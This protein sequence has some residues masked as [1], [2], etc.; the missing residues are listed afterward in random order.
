[1]L[2]GLGNTTR[3]HPVVKVN[4]N[5]PKRRSGVHP[6]GQEAFRQNKYHVSEPE[7]TFRG[8][9]IYYVYIPHRHRH[10]QA[11]VKGVEDVCFDRPADISSFQKCQCK[12]RPRSSLT[13][14]AAPA[15]YYSRARSAVKVQVS[16]GYLLVP[17]PSHSSV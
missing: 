9:V 3:L 2:L 5:A 13:S 8:P 11:R 17:S 7:R 14:P 6:F 4:R 10:I 12:L 15:F 1:M 16:S